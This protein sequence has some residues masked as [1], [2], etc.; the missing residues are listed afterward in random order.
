MQ[1]FKKFGQKFG[2]ATDKYFFKNAENRI[3]LTE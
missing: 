1:S 3:P 2:Q